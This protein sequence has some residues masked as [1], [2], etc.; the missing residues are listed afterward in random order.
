MIYITIYIKYCHREV[1]VGDNDCYESG[2]KGKGLEA[3]A[4]KA[5][6]GEDVKQEETE[7]V[8]GQDEHVPFEQINNYI[9][10]E[11]Q[12]DLSGSLE[13]K[14]LDLSAVGAFFFK[15]LECKLNACLWDVHAALSRTDGLFVDV[16]AI[17]SSKNKQMS[18]SMTVPAEKKVQLPCISRLVPCNT[19]NAILCTKIFGAA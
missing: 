14:A 15:K 11:F 9:S 6:Y 16:K 1:V 4:N 18:I 13:L 3:T 17:G 5:A 2:Q 8:Q 12:S 10:P 7:Q 19:K